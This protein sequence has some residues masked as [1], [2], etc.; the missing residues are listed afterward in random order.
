MRLC[1]IFNY[2]SSLG[3]SGHFWG[4]LRHRKAHPEQTKTRH[5]PRYHNHARRRVLN[6]EIFTKN[7]V[8]KDG[9]L[10]IGGL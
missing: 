2:V 1:R 3:R 9:F 6:T 10:R 8:D 7:I 4:Q 5:P